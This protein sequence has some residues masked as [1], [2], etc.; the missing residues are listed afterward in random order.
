MKLVGFD[1]DDGNRAKCKR[2]GVS[3][4]DIE[5]LFDT[6]PRVTPD[7]RHSDREERFIAVGRTRRGRAIFVAFTLRGPDRR[8]VRPISARFMH[9]KERK[10]HDQEGA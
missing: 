2:H 8:F 5:A 10:A 4:A 1:W 9:E 7:V 6:S 3:I